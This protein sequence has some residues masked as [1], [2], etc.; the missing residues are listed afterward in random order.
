MG[1]AGL[2]QF[3]DRDRINL[4]GRVPT[5]WGTRTGFI[6]VL[7]GPLLRYWVVFDQECCVDGSPGPSELKGFIIMPSQTALIGRAQAG[8]RLAE[9]GLVVPQSVASR[10]PTAGNNLLM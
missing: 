5:I 9:L 7:P 6:D 1:D 4:A 2:G 8:A 3:F 10:R